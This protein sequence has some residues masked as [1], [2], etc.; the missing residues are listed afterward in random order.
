[1]L[2]T[3]FPPSLVPPRSNIKISGRE[4]RKHAL[5]YKRDFPLFRDPLES[6]ERERERGGKMKG[7][8][9]FSPP[10]RNKFA[11][12]RDISISSGGSKYSKI[13]ERELFIRMWKFR[14]ARRG[15]MDYSWSNS[16]LFFWKRKISNYSSE[17]T[18][19]NLL[20]ITD[21]NDTIIEK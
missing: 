13:F 6:R 3:L 10:R 19:G 16:F 21:I 17:Y 14:C 12:E 18:F 11:N 5:A 4:K 7:G 8:T 2:S 20:F 1:M 9:F 15:I